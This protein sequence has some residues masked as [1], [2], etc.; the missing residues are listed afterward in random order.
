M[1]E[2]EQE[3][4]DR[5]ETENKELWENLNIGILIGVSSIIFILA[6]S[7]FALLDQKRANAKKYIKFSL[8]G[9]IIILFIGLVINYFLSE[10]QVGII[11]DTGYVKIIKLFL[12]MICMIIISI[13]FGD[14]ILNIGETRLGTYSH[15]IYMVCLLFYILLVGLL[16]FLMFYFSNRQRTIRYLE[17]NTDITSD[18][19]VRTTEI[20]TQMIDDIY[21]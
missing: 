14:K 17:E 20:R 5:E 19:E 16:L 2:T 21:K 7:Y 12:L 3:K 9:F 6:I 11:H 8:Q 4:K 13:I 1:I 15:I 18:Q 10:Y